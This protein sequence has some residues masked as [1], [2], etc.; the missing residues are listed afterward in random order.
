MLHKAQMNAYGLDD[1]VAEFNE[2][3]G[4]VN[5]DRSI[6]SIWLHA[7]E[8]ASMLHEDLRIGEY[9]NAFG[10][11]ADLFCWLCALTTKAHSE[12]GTKASLLDIVLCKYPRICFY[13]GS[14]P[15]ICSALIGRGIEDPTRKA[16]LE[17]EALQRAAIK[18]AL[19]HEQDDEPKSLQDVVEMFRTIYDHIN[20][21]TPIEIIMAHLQEEVGEVASVLNDFIDKP[22]ARFSDQYRHKLER[23][24][25]DVVTWLVALV[26]KLDYLLAAGAI[27]LIRTREIHNA[28]DKLAD[29]LRKHSLGITL[30]HILW[31][32]FQIPD[33]STLWCPSCKARPCNLKLLR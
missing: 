30:S 26:L 17:E 14:S 31:T 21:R 15:C 5:K 6:E 33:G 28:T 29:Y 16:Q 7:I 2:I 25:A 27:Y 13:C 20:F 8:H 24:I 11:I 4:G 32:H 23:E 3:Y 12:L 9:E 19:L 18:R 22:G 10:H 1:W